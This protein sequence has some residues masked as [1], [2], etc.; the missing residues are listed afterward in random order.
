MM[1]RLERDDAALRRI[2]K[3][4]NGYLETQLAR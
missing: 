4:L 1:S 2:Q 3:H